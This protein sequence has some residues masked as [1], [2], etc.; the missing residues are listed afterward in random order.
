MVERN[1][2]MSAK[3]QGSPSKIPKDSPPK[4]PQQKREK[5]KKPNKRAGKQPLQTKTCNQILEEEGIY[6]FI[7]YKK[8][9]RKNHP[10]KFKSDDPMRIA[11]EEKLKIIHNAI[12]VVYPQ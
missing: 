8:W 2:I 12:D 3:R 10:D 11:C 5:Y 6:S 1:I 7:D 4:K 9:I